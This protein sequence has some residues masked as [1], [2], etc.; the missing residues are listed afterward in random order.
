MNPTIVSD[1]KPLSA[2][3]CSTSITYNKYSDVR[4]HGKTY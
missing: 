2:T 4:F 1:N 3:R